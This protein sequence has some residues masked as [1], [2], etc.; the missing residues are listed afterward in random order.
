MKEAA[1]VLDEMFDAPGFYSAAWVARDPSFAALRDDDAYTSRLERWAAMKGELLLARRHEG[2]P[3]PVTA[4]P[5][6]IVSR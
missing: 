3:R 2:T 5:V 4:A 6:A 1:A